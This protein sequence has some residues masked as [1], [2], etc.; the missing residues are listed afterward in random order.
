MATLP[1]YEES[2]FNDNC[3]MRRKS[4]KKFYRGAKYWK[5][6]KSWRRAALLP[7]HFWKFLFEGRLLHDKDEFEFVFLNDIESDK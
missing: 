3:F 7:I 2:Q 4:D 5:Y 1:K 6:T